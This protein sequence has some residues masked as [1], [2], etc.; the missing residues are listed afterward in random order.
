M[1]RLSAWMVV[2][3]LTLSACGAGGNTISSGAA[4][5]VRDQHVEQVNDVRAQAGMPPVILSAELT[6]AALTHSRD[7][8][9][10]RRAW[11]F[12]SDATSPQDRAARAGY[13][14]TILGENIA[15]TGGDIEE[16]LPIWLSDPE[17]RRLILHPSARDIGF[18]WY[19]ESD[20]H[21][22]WVQVI[23]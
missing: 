1:F 7:M 15:E 13:F 14:G 22:W 17:T 19:Q 3:S 18:G 12:G 20:G 6:A 2:V 11:H 5:K 23:G 9:V 16:L 10:Q 8:A 4:T 21:S